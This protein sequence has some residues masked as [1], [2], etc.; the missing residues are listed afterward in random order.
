MSKYTI[1]LF[2]CSINS[3][4]TT[5]MSICK[6]DVEREDDKK[7]LKTN[8]ITEREEIFTHIP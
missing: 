4:N 2:R 3:V 6:S 5:L 7:D 1:L 8:K